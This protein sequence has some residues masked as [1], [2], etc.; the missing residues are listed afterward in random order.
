V[1]EIANTT[2]EV[3]IVVFGDVPKEDWAQ[4]GVLALES[5]EIHRLGD[6]GPL[7]HKVAAHPPLLSSGLTR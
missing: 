5:F 7:S 4:S 2:A 3:T 6:R 1:L